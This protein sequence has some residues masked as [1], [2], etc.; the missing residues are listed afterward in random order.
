MESRGIVLLAGGPIYTLNAYLNCRLLRW[1]GCSL[2]IEWHHLGPEIPAAY[3]ALI[4]DLPGVRLHD[5]GGDGSEQTK[6][7][8]G[9]QAKVEAILASQFRHVLWLDADCFPIRDP[10]Y[11]FDHPYY[12]DAGC[13]LWPDPHV[14]SSADLERLHGAFGVLLPSRQVESGQMM[15]DVERCQAGLLATRALNQ[16]HVHTYS[17]LYG[18]KDTFLIGA[19]QADSPVRICPHRHDGMRLGM[20]HKDFDG[21]PLFCHLAGGKWR[22]HGRAFVTEAD[23]PLRP[24]ALAII[25]ELRSAGVL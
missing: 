6:E 8:G 16:D 10:E 4:A 23:Y 7:K 24:Q 14:W 3:Q 15:F 12:R 25:A 18:D 22:P 1:M 21:Q 19:L 9:W 20:R 17:H 5:L 11:L 13:V 2:P